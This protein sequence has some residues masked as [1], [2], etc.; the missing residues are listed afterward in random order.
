MGST[1]SRGIYG[2]RRILK[3]LVD[4]NE[5]VSRTRVG[6]LMKQQGLE[7]KGKRK[8][9][10]TT[11]SNHGRPVAPNR[12]DREFMVEQPDT[13]YASDITYIQ[14]D[15]GRLYRHWAMTKRTEKL[16]D[17]LSGKVLSYQ[18]IWQYMRRNFLKP[19]WLAQI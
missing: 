4:D 15:E 10:A 1:T 19:D 11:N 3:D 5:C 12:L 18:S 16:R 6:R 2:A 9:K 14:T 8:F 7:S 17:Y 13:V